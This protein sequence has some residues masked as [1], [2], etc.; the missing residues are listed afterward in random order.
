MPGLIPS[1]G[2][3]QPVNVEPIDREAMETRS[4]AYAALMA[5]GRAAYA[6]RDWAACHEAFARAAEGAA[7]STDDLNAMATAAWQ[8]GR[9]REALRTAEQVFT[10]L[11]RT[12]PGSAAMKSVE[13]ALGWF[14]RGDLTIAQDWMNRTRRLLSGSAGVPTHGYLA[15]LDAMMADSPDALAEQVR[16]LR[17]LSA[18]LQHPAVTALCHTVEAQQAILEARMADAYDRIDEAMLPVLA[19]QLPV[20]WAGEIYWVVLDRCHRLADLPRLQDWTVSMRR[21]CDDFAASANHGRVCDV[22]RLHV[23]AATDDLPLLEGQLFAVS[24]ALED[25]NRRA[26]GEGYYQLGEVRR[27][28]GEV[29]GA[30]A[31]F[32]RA[33][34]MGVEPQPG[35]ALLQASQGRPDEAWKALRTVF[36]ATDRLGR[37]PLLEAMVR[38]ALARDDLDE[39]RRCCDEL[40]QGARAFGT[41]GFRAWAARTR[42]AVLLREGRPADALNALQAALDEQRSQHA[43][44]ET[45]EIHE[46]MATAHR[47]LG[48][49]AAAA[50][51]LAAAT[52]L[53]AGLSRG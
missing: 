38:V 53:Y 50:A 47:A 49:D 12:D 18:R 1:R 17:E 22:H 35:E 2:W 48:D 15:Y 29:A 10:R 28:R 21:W 41:P 4:D 24:R 19:D 25:V 20:D 14:T 30:F 34:T 27:R 42:G 36:A 11:V 3:L 39:A 37:M 45:A 33:R 44:F 32:A 51:D 5:A 16:T 9:G 31:A 23:L 8:V 26:S 46:W 6:R 13:L 40:E 7:L 52:E 43:R